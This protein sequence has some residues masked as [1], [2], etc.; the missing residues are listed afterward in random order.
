M[1][2][3][4]KHPSSPTVGRHPD[5]PA[6]NRVQVR[7]NEEPSENL[8]GGFSSILR[9]GLLSMTAALVTGLVLITVAALVLAKAPDPTTLLPFVAPCITGLCSLVGGIIAGR[10][11]KEHPM[12]ASAVCGGLLA[13]VLILVSFVFGS[14]GGGILPWILRLGVLPVH[15]IGGF[16][17]RPRSK[18]PSHKAGKH[19]S[20][21]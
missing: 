4:P 10:L 1:H 16:L 17:S 15:L 2:T 21:L 13:A 6:H 9:S 7:Q 8:S 3:T 12:A 14:E 18:A 5:R 11:Q 19:A 20:R